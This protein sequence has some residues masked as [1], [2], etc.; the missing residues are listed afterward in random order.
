MPKMKTNKSVLKRFH[1]TKGG[2]GKLMGLQIGVRHGRTGLRRKS[3][4]AKTKMVDVPKGFLKH[5]KNFLPYGV[6]H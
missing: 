3:I 6:K 4:R 1:A 2:S 5:I